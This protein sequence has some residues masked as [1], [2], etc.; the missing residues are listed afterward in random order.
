MLKSSFLKRDLGHSYTFEIPSVTYRDV[1]ITPLVTMAKKSS[2]N[3]APAK[4]SFLSYTY[5]QKIKYGGSLVSVMAGQ[6]A[7]TLACFAS[8]ETS[9][10]KHT[11]VLGNSWVLSRQVCLYISTLIYR[12]KEL[13]KTG[14]LTRHSLWEPFPYFLFNG[15][16]KPKQRQRQQ[17]FVSL[18]LPAQQQVL[19]AL[20]Q[21]QCGCSWILLTPSICRS[22]FALKHPVKWFIEW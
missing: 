11:E 12:E 6:P 15:S 21:L 1:T 13:L 3:Q 14:M 7:G 22:L 8:M 4:S 17:L 18:C 20:H 16:G 10:K 5:H 19:G 2:T 9:G